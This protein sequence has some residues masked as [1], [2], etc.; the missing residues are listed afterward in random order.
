MLEQPQAG[1]IG[2]FY[3]QV[4]NRPKNSDIF[5]I[6]QSIQHSCGYSMYSSIQ[7]IYSNFRDGSSPIKT[8]LDS[9]WLSSAQLSSTQLDSARLSPIFG[10]EP[11]KKGRTQDKPEPGFRLGP[12][13]ISTWWD[14]K[15]MLASGSI[16]WAWISDISQQHQF[17]TILRFFSQTKKSVF[18]SQKQRSER[19]L[20]PTSM[21]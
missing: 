19:K 6:S 10:S 5:Q 21:Y 18:V 1:L 2:R 15:L 12:I 8:Q 17:S 20:K 3:R 16:F 9:A 14:L 11:P 7:T 4:K 13:A